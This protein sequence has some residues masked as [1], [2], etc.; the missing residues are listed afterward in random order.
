MK[1]NIKKANKRK[2]FRSF[3]NRGIFDEETCLGYTD[4]L[5]SKK[6][7]ESLLEISKHFEDIDESVEVKYEFRSE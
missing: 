5:S 1:N 4:Y 6:L 3:S 2:M 7:N